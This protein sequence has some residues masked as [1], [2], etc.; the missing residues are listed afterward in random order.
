MTA[1][2][3]GQLADVWRAN[4]VGEAIY[5]RFMTTPR[6][7]SQ[8][9]PDRP[10]IP[11]GYGVPASTSGLLTWSAVEERLT[12][13]LHYWLAT[14][15]PD[16]TPHVVPRW[17]VWLDGRFWY[18]GAPVTRHARNRETNPACTLNLESGTEVVIVEGTATAARADA[19]G[20]GSRLAAA[21]S[22]YHP[23]GYRPEP[24]AWS[25]DDGGGLGVLTPRR[26]LA[27]FAF[28][29]DCTRFTFS[30]GAG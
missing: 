11:G 1:S 8:P 15:R 26:A 3:F 21:F 16:G 17:G 23:Y 24:D 20:L 2:T 30:A 6:P 27:W 12:A 29:H 18:D 28:P 7:S 25:G 5:G 14:V 9:L 22:K 4:H 13:S 19:D 10:T